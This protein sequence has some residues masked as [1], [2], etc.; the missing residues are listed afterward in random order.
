[1]WIRVCDLELRKVTFD[2][3]FPAEKI[4]LSASEFR[5]VSEL[6]VTGAADLTG[7]TEEIRVRGHISGRFER[8]CD[9]CLEAAPLEI[10][11]DFELQYRPV[12]EGSGE[13]DLDL[14]P[15]E[16]EVG[17]YEGGGIEL[18]DVVREQVLLWFPMHW[19]CND[20]CKGICPVC[21]ENRNRVPCGCQAKVTD[22]RWS[23]L[24]AYRR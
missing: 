12:S 19:I 15:G 13:A 20:G 2:L 14:D 5:P 21:G 18:A 4:D 10:D 1:M 3:A 6:R 24:R 22:D 23:A 9:R 8:D 7:G 17:Y 16:S 11:Q